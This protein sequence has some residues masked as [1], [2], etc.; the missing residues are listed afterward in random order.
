MRIEPFQISAIN[1]Y[2]GISDLYQIWSKII[3]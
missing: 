1:K 3:P 2:Q